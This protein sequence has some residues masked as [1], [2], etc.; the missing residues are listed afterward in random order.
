[1]Q[2]R[3]IPA[4]GIL[5]ILLTLLIMGDWLPVLRG[6][7]PD[8]SEWHWP[9]QL[10][11]L[12]SWWRPICAALLHALALA[13]LLSKKHTKLALT[14]LV[15]T[16]IGLQIGIVAADIARPW[17][18]L[19]EA[20]SA[21]LLD[22]T[23]SP[24]ASGYFWTAAHIDDIDTTLRDYPALMPAF[25]SEHARTHP[26]GLILLNW[27]TIEAADKWTDNDA[28]LA[29]RCV[30]LWLYGKGAGTAV[31]LAVWAWLPLLLGALCV[32]VAYVLVGRFQPGAAHATAALVATIPALLLFAPKVDQIFPLFALL[33]LW[34][35]TRTATPLPAFFSGLL[36]SAATMMTIGNAVIALPVGAMLLITRAMLGGW[37]FV[38][39][40]AAFALGCLSLWLI[41]WV[42]WGVSPMAIITTAL[43]QHYE[44]VTTI[45]R[46]DWWVWGNLVD[47]FFFAGMPLVLLFFPAMRRAFRNRIGWIMILS[48]TLV[49]LLLFLDLSGST[50]G[51]VGRI[52]LFLMPLIALV[53]G[54]QTAIKTT[55]WLCGMMLVLTVAI[56]L[57][58]EVVRPV[59]VVQSPPTPQTLA[60]ATPIN[61]SFSFATLTGYHIV[62]TKTA[63]TLDLEW[64]ASGAADYPYT[65]FVHVVA[66]DGTLVAQHDQWSLNGQWPPSCWRNGDRL[67][68]TYTLSLPESEPQPAALHIGFYHAQ[69]G[70]RVRDAVVLP[71][72]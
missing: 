12:N 54:S 33:A 30:D 26:P 37:R 67:I 64:E 5:T 44:L 23:L 42:G 60:Q 57:S 4:L 3:V 46:Y 39:D 21:E 19:P 22:R 10:R 68:D 11:P 13:L 51:E 50:R 27:L 40:T 65:T 61:E 35:L 70:A 29:Q 24:L 20:V 63:V 16:H 47:L 18:T 52:W 32:P 71:L 58:W 28:L 31:A 49:A 25:D 59:I 43:A 8:T 56:G 15:I 34:L 45:R 62:Q 2:R 6:P 69:T 7:A 55:R 17:R 36:L 48:V 53:V 1:M 66:A 9:Y 41:Y 14:L 38:S 72:P